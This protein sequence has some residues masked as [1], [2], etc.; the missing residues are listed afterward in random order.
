MIGYV[1]SN[2]RSYCL[3]FR[4]LSIKPINDIGIGRVKRER[5]RSCFR[6]AVL[7]SG[8]SL[9]V[10]LRHLNHLIFEVVGDEAPR[11]VGI[12]AESVQLDS[13]NLEWL[14]GIGHVGGFLV[15]V[16]YLAPCFAVKFET[17][18]HIESVAFAKRFDDALAFEHLLM[19]E[20]GK[21][22]VLWPYAV[23]DVDGVAEESANVIGRPFHWAG[24]NEVHILVGHLGP[25][26]CW[27]PCKDNIAHVLY[28]TQGGILKTYVLKI[29][30]GV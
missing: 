10:C 9:C 15:L 18:V 19:S 23:V 27:F 21:S 14:Q 3:G 13:V 26:L 1:F 2:R 25:F 12:G 5:E 7:E 29:R 6:L 17:R 20:R 8:A 16:V 28:V 4:F 11:P 22:D 24:A 30:G